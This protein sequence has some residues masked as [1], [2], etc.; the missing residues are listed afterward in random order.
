MA[1][2]QKTVDPSAQDG[3]FVKV[4]DSELRPFIDWEE[5]PEIIGRVDNVRVVTTAYGFQDVVDVGKYSVGLSS[6]LKCL[7]DMVGQTVKIHYDGVQ[8]LEG[9]TSYKKF[10]IYQK[11]ISE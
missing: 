11:K 5:V 9:G 4:K 2:K 6:A 8:S 1:T 10:T 7:K 3:E